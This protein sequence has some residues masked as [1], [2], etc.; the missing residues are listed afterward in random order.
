MDV[1]SQA[2]TNPG[3]TSNRR[4]GL[5]FVTTWDELGESFLPSTV[6]ADDF[7][8]S[9]HFRFAGYDQISEARRKSDGLAVAIR[10]TVCSQ[11]S[12][13]TVRV[14]KDLI[15]ILP[16]LNHPAIATFIG[17]MVD[18]SQ[19]HFVFNYDP[20]I[21]SI[22]ALILTKDFAEDEIGH[23]GAQLAG[24]LDYLHA[25]KSIV[26]ILDPFGILLMPGSVIK[27]VDI[28][29]MAIL[30]ANGLTSG[31][32]RPCEE[33]APEALEGREYGKSVDWWALGAMMYY[34]STKD[35]PFMISMFQPQ[36]RK[37]YIC[38]VAKPW[39]YVCL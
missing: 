26:R 28:P 19:L 20:L 16:R 37:I 17:H 14:L 9:I 12:H 4:T 32:Y 18:P 35:K 24:A 30:G 2:V 34:L 29:A 36:L 31:N 23:Y 39:I 27:L 15:N 5:F 13:S 11:H 3:A 7:N 10:T 6:M 22:E 1:P 38:N 33:Q 21:T 8:Q 25:Q